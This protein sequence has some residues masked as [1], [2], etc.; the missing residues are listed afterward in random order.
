MSE[1]IEPSKTLQTA[2][3]IVNNSEQLQQMI[4]DKTKGLI[5][6]PEGYK[7]KILWVSESSVLGTGFSNYTNEILRRLHETDEYEIAE[8]GSYVSAQDPRLESIPW[9][10]FAVLPDVVN[11]KPDPQQDQ[12]YRT[13]NTNQFGE[14]K[15]DSVIAEFKPDIVVDNRDWW[16]AEFEERSK[17]KDNFVWILLVPVDGHPQKWEWIASYERA[18]KVLTYSKYGKKV[19]E[20]QSGGKIKVW[21]VPSPGAD[22][23][24]FKPMDKEKIRD[25]YCIKPELKIIGTVMRNQARKQ[26]PSLIQAFRYYHDHYPKDFKNT[27]L[28]IHTSIPDVG[29]DI[30]ESLIRTGMLRHV[31]FTYKCDAC[32]H[33]FVSW[34]MSKKENKFMGR[35]EKCGEMKAHTPNTQ[36]FLDRKQLAEIYN[37]FDVYVQFS[38]SEGFGMPIVEAKA[39]GVPIMC[40]DNT[41]MSEQA[42]N[43]GGFP[44]PTVKDGEEFSTFTECLG[45]TNGQGM[46]EWDLP[47]RVG[48]AKMWSKFFNLEKEDR[49]FLSKQARK[50]VEEHYDWNKCGE[51][52]K[53]L[54]N[55]TQIKDREQYWNRPIFLLNKTE[56]KEIKGMV[57]IPKNLSNEDFILYLY[58]NILEEEVEDGHKGFNDWMKSMD[59]GVTRD[60]IV[61]YFVQIADN[62]NKYE[63]LRCGIFSPQNIFTNQR[64]RIMLI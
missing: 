60:Q 10:H 4:K 31:I 46:R 33:V 39:C 1:L 28:H 32:D 47:S 6:K 37:L 21:G 7:L 55:N 35:C 24:V 2:K 64:R 42:R 56:G 50:C 48:L 12:I 43:G 27:V 16:M 54:F 30:E 44:I 58:D 25:K 62:N 49:E 40:T 63:Y 18:H 26:Y 9:K 11:G 22:L 19:L 5:D 20:Q 51:F 13:K 57:D 52:W 17:F 36:S 29:W 45:T 15:F 53:D 3:V 41:A 23:D 38:I 14:W 61:N 34:F 59:S 8:M